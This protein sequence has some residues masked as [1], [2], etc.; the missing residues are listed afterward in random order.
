MKKIFIPVAD[1]SAAQSILP[2]NSFV[3]F[4]D[5]VGARV[6][7]GTFVFVLDARNGAG[8]KVSVLDTITNSQYGASACIKATHFGDADML[9]HSEK[10]VYLPKAFAVS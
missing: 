1:F 5:V 9:K 10:N 8:A 2:H 3:C 4:D 7:Y 6:P